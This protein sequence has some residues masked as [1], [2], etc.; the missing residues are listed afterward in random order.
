MTE[1]ILNRVENATIEELFDLSDDVLQSVK[2][3][4][5]TGEFAQAFEI[6]DAYIYSA[7]WPSYDRPM[8]YFEDH[9]KVVDFL[10]ELGRS[11]SSE[12]VQKIYEGSRD[13]YWSQY[14]FALGT[15]I[16]SNTSADT[17]F[18]RCEEANF[19]TEEGQLLWAAI[20]LRHDVRPGK[21]AEFLYIGEKVQNQLFFSGDEDDDDDDIEYDEYDESDYGSLAQYL[22]GILSGNFPAWN[23]FWNNQ[24]L[25]EDFPRSLENLQQLL[26]HI[27]SFDPN[28]DAIDWD[29]VNIG[30]DE[31]IALLESLIS[32]SD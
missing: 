16:N 21:F 30:R 31:A 14:V 13:F 8:S 25:L 19:E 5:A 4:I 3:L 11:C 22:F 20:L 32:P 29:E 27:N 10:F 28:E 2:D 15:T 18:A 17:L 9:A 1:S 12:L 23:R 24:V 7:Q 26:D 6:S